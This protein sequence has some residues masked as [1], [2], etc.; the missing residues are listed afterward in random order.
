MSEARLNA[1]RH[2]LAVVGIETLLGG[3]P[4]VQQIVELERAVEGDLAHGETGESRLA[5]DQGLRPRELHDVLILGAEPAAAPAC[6]RASTGSCAGSGRGAP[7]KWR[8]DRSWRRVRPCPS[9]EKISPAPPDLPVASSVARSLRWPGQTSWTACSDF[10]STEAMGSV[11]GGSPVR[12]RRRAAGSCRPAISRRPALSPHRTPS[13]HRR[14][15]YED[16]DRI[17]NIQRM[18]QD[19]GV[20]IEGIRRLQ[21]LLPCWDLLP[22]SPQQREQCPAFRDNTRPCWMI[23]GWIAPPRTATG[24]GNVWFTALVRSAPSKSKLCCTIRRH[25]ECQRGHPRTS[26]YANSGAKRTVE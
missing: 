10:G 24:A 16:V 25:P 18:V 2:E 4:A 23:K 6:A 14:F 20:S 26:R 8:R 9:T 5:Q 11:R 12:G 13:G 19:L 1:D 22:C 21:A 7:A 3:L 17:R 15:S